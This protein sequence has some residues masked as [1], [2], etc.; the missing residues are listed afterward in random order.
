[1]LWLINDERNNL[2]NVT[3]TT[4]SVYQAHEMERNFLHQEVQHQ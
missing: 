1:M 4:R 3:L 2:L